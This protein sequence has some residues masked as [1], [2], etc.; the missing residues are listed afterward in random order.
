MKHDWV[1]HFQFTEQDIPNHIQKSLQFSQSFLYQPFLMN[2]LKNEYLIKECYQDLKSPKSILL[3][4]LYFPLV[5]LIPL[6]HHQLFQDSCSHL[7]LMAFH[8]FHCILHCQVQ[9]YYSA[10]I[11]YLFLYIYQQISEY[12]WELTV[13]ICFPLCRNYQIC[14]FL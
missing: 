12:Y 5:D 11:I 1:L 14:Y 6:V 4:D 3:F 9:H 13:I 7:I 10:Y 8:H 2:C